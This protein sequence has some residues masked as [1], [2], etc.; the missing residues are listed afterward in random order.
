LNPQ[1]AV[2]HRHALHHRELIVAA[3]RELVHQELGVLS[4]GLQLCCGG[5]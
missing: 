5:A 2:L 3:M 4:P 1:A